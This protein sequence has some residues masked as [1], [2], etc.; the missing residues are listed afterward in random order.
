VA[1]VFLFPGQNSRYPFMLQKVLDSDPASGDW[2]DRASDVLGRDIRAHYRASNPSMFFRNRDVQIGVFLANH[3]HWRMLER[4]GIRASFSA[5]LS[6]GEYNHLVHIGALEFDDALR[7]LEARG[8]AYDDGP[9][10]KMT[11]VFPASSD[12]MRQLLDRVGQPAHLGVGIHNTPRQQVLSG[13][14]AAVDAA[15]ALAEEELSAHTVVIDDR[16]PMHSPLFDS[17]AETLRPALERASWHRPLLPCLPNVAGRFVSN[18]GRR[19]F[20]DLLSRHVS[21]TVRWRESMETIA[22]AAAPMVVIEAGPGT[23]LTNLFGRKWLS[24]RRFATD[25]A[26]SFGITLDSLLEELTSGRAGACEPS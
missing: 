8:N 24:P 14:A 11:A 3:L 26:E 16:L 12:D 10:G 4:A 2:L 15:A 6:L 22:E 1:L 25:A 9:R 21:H 23:V 17:V 7:V 13:D 19:E 18:P 20:V 5:G